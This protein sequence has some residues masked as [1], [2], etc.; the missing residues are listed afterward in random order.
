MFLPQIM[1]YRLFL[2]L[3]I[4]TVYLRAQTWISL[5]DSNINAHDIEIEVLTSNVNQ[6]VF[7]VT[8]NGFYKN[9][10]IIGD[11]TYSRLYIKEHEALDEI[12]HPELPVVNQLLGIPKGTYGKVTVSN[13]TWKDFNGFTV[14]PFQRN[15][16]E[17]ETENEFSK[18]ADVYNSTSYYPSTTY[19]FGAVHDW[20]GIKIQNLALCPFHYLPSTSQLHVMKEFTVK[21][22]FIEIDNTDNRE[23]NTEIFVDDKLMPLMLA[24]YN[25]ALIDS[26][27]IASYSRADNNVADV[28]KYNFLIISAPQ[29]KNDPL[30]AQ[31][32]HSKAKRGFAC[33]VVSTDETGN[34]PIRIKNFIKSQQVNG[35]RYV[36]FIG[37]EEDIPMYEWPCKIHYS[38]N[39]YLTIP[40]P[41]DYWYGCM[42]DDTDYIAEMAIGRFCVSDVS[43]LHNMINKHLLYSSPNNHSNDW[44]KKCVLIADQEDAQYELYELSFQATSE[45]IRTYNYKNNPE[46]IIQY[47]ADTIFGGNLAT[48][49]TVVNQINQ[50]V[51]L[52]AYNGH[53]YITSWSAN[54]SKDSIAFDSTYVNQ[55]TCPVIHPVVLSFA[56]QTAN[57]PVHF[58]CLMESFTTKNIAAVAFFGSTIDASHGSC[59]NLAKTF[60]KHIYDND[61]YR[62]GDINLTAE[63]QVINSTVVS[64]GHEKRNAASFLWGG[65]PT[66]ELWTDNPK[67]FSP[68]DIE[69][70]QNKDSVTVLI[71]DSMRCNISL[72]SMDDFGLSYFRKVEN[73]S[74]Y[75]FVGVDVP[76]YINVNKHNYLPY[77]FNGNVTVNSKTID[78]KSALVGNDITIGE[79][80]ITNGG[81]LT[82]KAQNEVTLNAGFECKKG[83]ILEIK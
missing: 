5:T 34:T 10:I 33:K 2:L 74:S 64:Y 81:T 39:Y 70:I 73:V 69:V 58:D 76:C 1:R 57:F 38:G 45:N 8:I 62:I 4:C 48:N 16:L 18:N 15:L 46:F 59:T 53:G 83:G 72:C 41:S 9:D 17:S 49:G 7:N 55:L 36:L 12:G 82:I 19:S 66:L 31:Y 60:F 22:D 50:G 44:A 3:T 11:T 80:T 25:D 28:Q 61:I 14:Y 78:N 24:N 52:V 71:A 23:A 21:V 79:T 13:I 47:G 37:D 63:M 30:L 43:E 75:T 65:D 40:T 67:S 29:Y 27:R 51:G 54:W 6:Y 56:C 42:G 32:L 35:V 77:T 26:Y 20:G 68:E